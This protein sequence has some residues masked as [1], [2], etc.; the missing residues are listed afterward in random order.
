MESIVLSNAAI[1]AFLVITVSCG[2]FSL[3]ARELALAELESEPAPVDDVPPEAQV[4]E[5]KC[6]TDK[7]CKILPGCIVGMHKCVSGTCQCVP[8]KPP[9]AQPPAFP[10]VT[11]NEECKTLMD[12][13]ETLCPDESGLHLRCIDGICQCV[14]DG[15]SPVIKP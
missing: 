2:S 13:N 1:L 4:T 11:V 15:S 6:S 8:F 10:M 14:P 3:A 9:Q 12:C 7:D 5:Q